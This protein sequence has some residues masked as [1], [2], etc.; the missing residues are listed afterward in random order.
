MKAS[1]KSNVRIYLKWAVWVLVIQFILVNISASTYAYKFTHFYKSP[2][3]KVSGQNIFVKTWKLFVG[4]S[5]YKNTGEPSPSFPFDTVQLKTSDGIHIDGWYSGSDTS[6]KCVIFFHGITV[7]KSYL[8][9][10]A[11]VFRSWGY[12][13]LLVDFRGHGRSGGS[14]S[15]FGIKETGE[16]KS[17]FSFAR[18]KGNKKIILYGVSMGAGVCIRAVHLNLVKPDA[19]IADMPFGTLRN[20][21]RSR[22]AVLGFPSEPFATLVTFWMGVENGY[23]GFKYDIA[24]YAKDITCPVLIEWGEEDPY[25]KKYEIMKVFNNLSSG[26]KKMVAYASAGHESFLN[27]NP[28]KWQAE[29]KAFIE[30]SDE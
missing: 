6:K 29:V 1:S 8:A 2:P 28:I 15:T 20:H 19:I 4:P 27:F 26:N 3:P 30:K 24:S 7:N 22:A 16:V 5:F 17:A 25:V 9:D 10:E 11:S 21:L 18:S 23:N 12:N 13:V 14:E